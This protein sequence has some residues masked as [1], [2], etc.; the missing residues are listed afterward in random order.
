[1]VLLCCCI[2]YFGSKVLVFQVWRVN[3][4]EHRIAKKEVILAIA[5]TEA[6]FIEIGWVT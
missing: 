4:L 5:K 6:H 1:M 3:Q 2:L